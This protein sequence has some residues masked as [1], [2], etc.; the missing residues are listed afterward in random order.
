MLAGSD[1]LRARAREQQEREQ[2]GEG[3]G[4]HAAQA[5]P[6]VSRSPESIGRALA[7][8][9]L[10]I[11]YDLLRGGSVYDANRLWR[12]FDHERHVA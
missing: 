11:A 12:A 6:T 4:R 3:D 1:C 5:Y 2:D 10:R 9:L 8:H 7:L